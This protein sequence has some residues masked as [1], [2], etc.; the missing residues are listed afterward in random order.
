MAQFGEGGHIYMKSEGNIFLSA[1][2][3]MGKIFWVSLNYLKCIMEKCHS[4][5]LNLISVIFMHVHNEFSHLMNACNSVLCTFISIIK[6]FSWQSLISLWTWLA[7]HQFRLIILM[8]AH[9]LTHTHTHIHTHTHLQTHACMCMCTCVCM[10][11]HTHT[12]RKI[13]YKDLRHK[14]NTGVYLLCRLP[15]PK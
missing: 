11:T 15:W 2:V 13:M 6:I 4:T 14:T 12:Q 10:H 8:H 3:Q 5:L 7:R 1:M 9:A